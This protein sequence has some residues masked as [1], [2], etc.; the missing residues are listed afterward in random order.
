MRQPNHYITS[1]EVVWYSKKGPITLQCYPLFCLY[2]SSC[3]ANGYCLCNLL[4]H[5]LFSYRLVLCRF[6]INDTMIIEKLKKWANHCCY[7]LF[8]AF[9]FQ[10]PG[11]PELVSYTMPYRVNF[12]HDFS[13]S[14]LRPT[15]GLPKRNYSIPALQ[16]KS[17][18]LRISIWSCFHSRA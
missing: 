2:G 7:T 1:I 11:V 6:M 3:H 15:E 16:G 10:T 18:L 9:S 8:T 13:S 4:Q 5:K 17:V 14:A 12:G